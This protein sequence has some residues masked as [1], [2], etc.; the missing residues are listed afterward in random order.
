MSANFKKMHN[1]KAVKIN[2]VKG[3]SKNGWKVGGTV[4]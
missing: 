3:G 2:C 1:I 4:K